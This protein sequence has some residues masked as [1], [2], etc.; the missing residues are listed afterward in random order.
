M[1]WSTQDDAKSWVRNQ[2]KD[3]EW[4]IDLSVIENENLTPT[5]QFAFE[6]TSKKLLL[7]QVSYNY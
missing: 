5:L 6:L 7:V 4:S 2:F 3:E 1:Q